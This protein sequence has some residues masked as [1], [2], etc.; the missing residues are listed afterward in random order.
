M[1]DSPKVK[2]VGLELHFGV[3]PF[4]LAPEHKS[5][6]FTY[7]DG[8]P[9]L[10]LK[11]LNVGEEYEVF[12]FNP[13]QQPVQVGEI[14]EGKVSIRG[15][16][17]YSETIYTDSHGLRAMFDD[18]K[19][20]ISPFDRRQYIW[21]HSAALISSEYSFVLKDVESKDFLI[22]AKDNHGKG[23]DVIEIS[24]TISTN[25]AVLEFWIFSMMHY[26]MQIAYHKKMEEERRKIER[27]EHRKDENE[28]RRREREGY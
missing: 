23:S 3:F 22:K 16:K 8:Q 17:H 27:A 4:T 13:Q 5:F 2:D 20:A 28:E 19:T 9:L 21:Q 7:T 10:V 15:T 26:R 11:K 1:F 12:E 14:T 25:P 18:T 24:R 6:A